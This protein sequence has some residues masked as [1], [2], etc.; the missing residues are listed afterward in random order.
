MIFSSTVS[1]MMT[2]TPIRPLAWLTCLLLLATTIGCRYP[3]LQSRGQEIAKALDSAMELQDKGQLQQAR[4]LIAQSQ[5]QG[6]LA[7]VEVKSLLAIIAVAESGDW[8]KARRQNRQLLARQN[9]W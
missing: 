2:S 9:D 4:T 1:N 5:Q 7:S 8:D 6:D 3:E